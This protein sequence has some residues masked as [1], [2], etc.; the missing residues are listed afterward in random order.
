MT[1]EPSSPEVAKKPIAA[2]IDHHLFKHV[3][4]LDVDDATA[5][6]AAGSSASSFGGMSRRPNPNATKSTLTTGN[7]PCWF[8]AL[9]MSK[10]SSEFIFVEFGN[11][12]R[13]CRSGFFTTKAP[14]HQER[15]RRLRL[16]QEGT[17]ITEKIAPAASVAS[18]IS[19]S[20][21]SAFLVSLCL[22]GTSSF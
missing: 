15:Q 7:D 8:T 17:A 21:L 20:I 2:A 9:R 1:I 5:D 4:C 3:L 18:V 22:G 12:G 10:M 6:T 13:P 14:R 16:K 11:F 19:C